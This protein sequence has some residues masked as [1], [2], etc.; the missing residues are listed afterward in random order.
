MYAGINE[1]GSEQR[2]ARVLRIGKSAENPDYRVRHRLAPL[3]GM[4]M[5]EKNPRQAG[6]LSVEQM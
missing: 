1:A 5:K 6:S 2:I 3:H 4:L